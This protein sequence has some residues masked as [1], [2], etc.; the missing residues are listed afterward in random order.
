METLFAAT[1]NVEAMRLL[2]ADAAGRCK[3]KA[4]PP[5]EIRTM[6]IDIRR[7]Y[8]HAKAQREV[9][10]KLP[11]EDPRGDDPSV[12]GLLNQ[13]LYGTRDAGANWHEEYS[14]FLK[15][16]DLLQG[17]TNPC[18]FFSG[19]HTLKGIVHGTISSSQGQ[20]IS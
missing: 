6:I 5:Q 3:P 2:L 18:H 7:A 13:S 11:P 17:S 15:S 10:V 14:N 16:I 20:P 4:Q 19:D 8:F 12:C 9:Y 1:P